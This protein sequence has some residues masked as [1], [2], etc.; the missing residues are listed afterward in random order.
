MKLT[1]LTENH[2]IMDLINSCLAKNKKKTIKILNDNYFSNEDCIQISRT[3]LNKSK[4]LLTLLNV[5]EKNRNLE[6]TISSA[7]PPIFWKD[8][9]ITKEQIFK[10][11]S[12]NMEK[13][14]YEI[15][16]LEMAMKKNINNSINL[17][18]NFMLE[19]SSS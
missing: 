13:L 1:N 3:L 14:I 5:Y 17:I 18:T 16:D 11:P 12:K 9:E 7:K 10:W 19:K 15:N 6:L 8:K 4:K 2:S